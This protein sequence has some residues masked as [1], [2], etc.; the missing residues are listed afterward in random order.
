[1]R[2]I[3]SLY[4]T[5]NTYLT[6][7]IAIRWARAST[8]GVQGEDYERPAGNCLTV[9]KSFLFLLWAY[10]FDKDALEMYYDQTMAKRRI[11]QLPVKDA[12][13]CVSV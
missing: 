7:D 12:H 11:Y 3:Y 9:A 6:S 8:S 4:N 1:M 5:S 2:L 13:E 10:G